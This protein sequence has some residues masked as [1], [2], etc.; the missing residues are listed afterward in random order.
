MLFEVTAGQTNVGTSSGFPVGLR[1][2]SWGDG[3]VRL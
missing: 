1:T 2:T 3:V